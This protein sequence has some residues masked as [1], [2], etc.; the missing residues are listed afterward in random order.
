[1]G[2]SELEPVTLLE[3]H[4]AHRKEDIFT[5]HYCRCHPWAERG[6]C[7]HQM[8]LQSSLRGVID[9]PMYIEDKK[10]S[11]DEGLLER[12]HGDIGHPPWRESAND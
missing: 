4:P 6:A 8:L 10:V 12:N 5:R 11:T 9:I 2:L 1:M 3:Q 7:T